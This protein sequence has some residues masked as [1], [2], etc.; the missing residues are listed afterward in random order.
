VARLN[1]G[2]SLARKL[3]W[4]A[5]VL[6]PYLS[7]HAQ[8]QELLTP[9]DTSYFRPGEDDWNLVEAVLHRD[10][11]N[12]LMLLNRGADPNAGD[13]GGMTALMHAAEL[14]DVMLIKLLILNGAEPD[15]T[16]YENTTPLMIAVLN[17]NFDAAH[18]LLQKGADPDYRDDYSGTPLLYAAAVNDYRIADLLLFYG[19]SDT[20]RDRDGN[21]ALMT[22]VFF[23]NIETADVLL[24]DHLDP[25]VPDRRG[26]TPLMI[27]ARQGNTD[28]LSLLLEYD[29]AIDRVN[30]ENYTA[31]AQAIA[32]R[33]PGAAMLLIDSGANI[34]HRIRPNRN[35]YDMALQEKLTGVRKELKHRGAVPVLKP[36][37]SGFD[38]G[39]GNSLGAHEYMM[40]TRVRWMD[41]KF[42]WYG[43]T[44]F[45]FRPYP[46][47]VHVPENDTLIFQYRE[48]RYVWA[49]GIGKDFSLLRDRSGIRY[50]VYTSLT[51]M[52]SF[53]RYRG[54][55]E[56]PRPAYGLVPAAGVFLKWNI[57]GIR[58]GT[59]RYSF[60]TMLEGKWKWNL[61][62]FVSINYQKNA[63][64]PKDINYRK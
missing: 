53:P 36:D 33:Q 49:H 26:N 7:V 2:I 5:A 10:Y 50:G 57:G 25:D 15:L 51:G 58:M 39:W 31:L 40:Q 24:Q 37:F 55:E 62:L 9:S 47:K 12:V 13:E 14:G 17:E 42:G 8:E 1:H 27:A 30:R 56:H 48:H 21:S 20:V 3:L 19:A 28:M 64:E 44:G 60:G 35:L 54:L 59:E 34:H 52:L 45:D 18:Y 32:F 6:F 38:A 11:G 16:R 61:T 4:L 63:L 41:S 29:A 43:E 23:N 22:A 46:Q